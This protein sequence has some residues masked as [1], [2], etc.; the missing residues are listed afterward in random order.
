MLTIFKRSIVYF[1]AFI[2]LNILEEAIYLGSG[3][4]EQRWHICE[5]WGIQTA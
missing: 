5:L 4:L 1:A 2:I 3:G